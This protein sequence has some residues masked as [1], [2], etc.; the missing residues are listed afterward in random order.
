MS[1]NNYTPS[2]SFTHPEATKYYFEGRWVIL[3]EMC[4]ILNA[5]NP[6]LSYKKINESIIEVKNKV[7]HFQGKFSWDI[8]KDD[9]KK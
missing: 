9:E 6:E 5:K 4:E 1:T 7:M 8:E 3:D 2:V